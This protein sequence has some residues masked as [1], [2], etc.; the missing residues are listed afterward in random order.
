MND[1]CAFSESP[2]LS[3]YLF[4]E[5]TADERQRIAAHLAT[6][7]SCQSELNTFRATVELVRKGDAAGERLAP[8]SRERVIEAARSA[9]RKPAFRVPWLVLV[10]SMAALLI[11]GA[12]YLYVD[13][14]LQRG[15]EHELLAA[16]PAAAPPGAASE[17]E[18]RSNAERQLRE[19]GYIGAAKRAPGTS[20]DPAGQAGDRGGADRASDSV[21][22]HSVLQVDQGVKQGLKSLGYGAPPAAAATGDGA[23]MASAAD[24]DERLERAKV[25]RVVPGAPAAPAS[26]GRVASVPVDS[27]SSTAMDKPK[28][29]DAASPEAASSRAARFEQGAGDAPKDE[30]VR[31]APVRLQAAPEPS[32]DGTSGGEARGAPPARTSA[33]N[34]AERRQGD[35]GKP[36]ETAALEE[37]LVA[38]QI[39]EI[40]ARLR[41]QP[42]EAPRD[43]FFR[44]WG[45]HAFV[46]AS[47]HPVSTF[48]AD[49]DSASYTLARAYL[50]A[51]NLPTREQVR[52]EE[53]VNYFG[54]QI[55]P[56][57]QGVF[58]IQAEAAASPFADPDQILL[59]VGLKARTVASAER[60][61]CALTFVVD[62]SGSM[63]DGNRLE[64]VK[65]ALRMLVDQ[66]DEGDRIGIVAFSDDATKVLDPVPASAKEHIRS[67][68]GTLHP[69][70]ATNAA[71][72]LLMG[73]TMAAGARLERGNNRV[74]LC[75]DGVANTGITD[76]G[77]MLDGVAKHR[78]QGIL[79]NCIGV[80]MG[81]HNDAL[82]E[83]LADR[84]DG[85]CV[86]FDRIEEARRVFRD[87]LTATLETVARDVKIQ[88]EFAPATVLRYRQLGYENRALLDQD[89]RNDQVDAGEVGAGHEVVALY[90]LTMRPGARGQIA[91]IRVRYKDPEVPA[92][93]A[94][95]HRRLDVAEVCRSFDAANPRFELS[96]V[97][98]EFAELLRRSYWAA[99][100][101]L[102]SLLPIA[103][104]V[105]KRLPEDQSVAEL[106]A[107]IRQ[108]AEL[109]AQ[110]PDDLARATDAVMR[111]N[112]LI[113]QLEDRGV[114]DAA[115]EQLLL[116]NE[117]LRR[118]I[119][120]LLQR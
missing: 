57:E 63:R 8:A 51:G 103:E 34:E 119:E 79:L 44:Y 111:N 70:G 53:F 37:A 12:V 5:V 90:E 50:T 6:C 80:G 73:Y 72:G 28:K 4:D 40:F 27:R 47:E 120:A 93:V 117:K 74:I 66:L 9:V 39:D 32:A 112:Y 95:I 13:H 116:Q 105:A 77:Q 20:R 35:R 92:E 64:L 55:P 65:D 56:P 33:T 108:A 59:K 42:G 104:R 97:A 94:E 76:Q 89:F 81:N 26:R 67:A 69:S 102:A 10:Q 82:L 43:M 71:A 85:Q 18:P 60:K 23:S 99:S 31:E 107:L 19:L 62:V 22:E 54:S 36:A 38:R 96:A 52:T 118:E 15:S 84:G 115:L 100:D 91:D 88:V 114:H 87:Q 78:A 24:E 25:A 86:Y 113:A 14:R 98:A 7:A 1:A 30:I 68:I 46:E 41:R 109:K 49:V 17:I 11:V 21:E 3:R 2:D 101:S 45:D 16:R 61:A 58:R 106:C 48:A 110:H 83:Q 29:S 75:S